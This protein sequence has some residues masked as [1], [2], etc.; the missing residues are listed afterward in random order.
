MVSIPDCV[1]R[2]SMFVDIAIFGE[3]ECV[4][5]TVSSGIIVGNNRVGGTEFFHLYIT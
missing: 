2:D 1:Y 4:E 3:T 5:R